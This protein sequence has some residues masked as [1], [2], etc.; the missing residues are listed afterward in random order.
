MNPITT[1]ILSAMTAWVPITDHAYYERREITE[2]RY[3]SIANT[4]VETAYDDKRKPL[5]E[6]EDG[7][8]KS[9]LLL[10]AIASTE[11]FFIKDVD[12]C[13]RGGDCEG[14]HCL[15]WGDWQ[16][17]SNRWRTC[18]S[19]ATAADIAYNWIQNSF[20]VCKMKGYP[21][22]DRLSVYTDGHCH[23]NWERSRTRMLRALNWLKGHPFDD[24][25]HQSDQQ[26]VCSIPPSY[27][28]VPPC[29]MFFSSTF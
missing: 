16:T 8:I 21:M 14:G 22:L 10:A 5:F 29:E 13:R 23:W 24:G 4:V 28:S 2:A 3:V 15:A 17:H 19:R 25:T 27:A 18:S 11:S 1:Y 6:G 12:T 9:A 26:I 20:D 7:R